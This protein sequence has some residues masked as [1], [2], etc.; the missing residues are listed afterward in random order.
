MSE[1]PQKPQPGSSAE[2]RPSPKPQAAQSPRRRSATR[3]DQ[4]AQ[5]QRLVV[6]AT[7][8][9]LAIALI[10][11]ISG[12]LYEQVWLPGRPVARVADTTLSRSDYWA[13]RREAYIREIV[14]NFQLL[15][16][17]GGNPQFTQQF[18][19]QSPNIQ[20]LIENVR[21]LDVDEAVVSG[22]I[23]RQV[24][25]RGA[26]ELGLSVNDDEVNQLLVRD[27]GPIFLPPPPAPITETVEPALEPSP[28]ATGEAAADVTPEATTEVEATAELEFT[29]TSEPTFT[30]AP[31][32]GP[33]EAATQVDEIF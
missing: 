10:A 6:F 3:H 8:G 5:R 30:P 32:P 24:K 19:N 22:W 16:L 11:I 1:T 21:S 9:A 23:D 20:A 29:P 15:A 26:Q 17:F 2:R 28:E 13:E 18:Q 33:A 12:L 27:L 25:Q 31:T 14:Q 7:A 4:E